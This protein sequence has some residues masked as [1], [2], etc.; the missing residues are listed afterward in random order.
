MH[1]IGVT[2]S[3]QM[4]YESQSECGMLQMFILDCYIWVVQCGT[5]KK[6]HFT[7]IITTLMTTTT[8]ITTTPSP[9]HHHPH[10]YHFTTTSITLPSS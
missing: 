9:P 4:N 2:I 1:Y 10:Q 3:V 5:L 7:T 6:Y 8:A